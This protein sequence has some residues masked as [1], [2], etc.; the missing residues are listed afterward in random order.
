[1]STPT[2]PDSAEDLIG[3]V[4]AKRAEVE[5]YLR[6][7]NAR[8]RRLVTITIFAGAT[9]TALTAAPALGG[10]PLTDWLTE[11]FDLASPAWRIL[12]ALASVCSLTA[13][14]ATQLH[15]SNNYEEHI[16]RAQEIK[17]TLEALEVAIASHHL[18]EHEATS[19]Y[20]RTI[21]DTSFIEAAG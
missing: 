7:M 16:A 11:T 19:Q 10:E 1:V 3:R 17:A 13:A 15:R 8:R 4:H 12:C 21:E 6:A 18:S 20:L 5:Q 2:A 9:A 14:I